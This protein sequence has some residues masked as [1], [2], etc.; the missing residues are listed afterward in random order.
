MD[1]PRMWMWVF[2]D[3]VGLV[4]SDHKFRTNP[5]PPLINNYVSHFDR[6]CKRDISTA[7]TKARSREPA[8]SLALI[9]N[10]IDRQR[11][12]SRGSGR[13]ADSQTAMVDSVR[14]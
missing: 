3:H 1:A 6:N 2:P 13:Q 12:R 8:Y 7:P 14:S 11:V 4:N 5:S 9:Q 10:K